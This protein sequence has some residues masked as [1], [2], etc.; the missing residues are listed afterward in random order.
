MVPGCVFRKDGLFRGVAPQWVKDLDHT[1]LP[2]YDLFDLRVSAH[3]VAPAIITKRGCAFGCTYCPYSKL[4]GKHYRLKSPERVLAEVRHILQ[5]SPERRVTFCDNNFNAPRMH[6]EQLCR[7]FIAAGSD[8]G[9]STGSLKPGGVTDEL[10]HLMRDSGCFYARS[11]HRVR[12]RYDVA[13]HEAWIHCPT[14]A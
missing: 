12:L 8:F 13:A 9:W 5:Y 7:A 14:G 11:L 1:A 10:C 3:Q 4:E 2:A 6:A